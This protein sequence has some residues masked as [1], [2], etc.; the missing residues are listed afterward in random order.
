MMIDRYVREEIRRG[1]CSKLSRDQYKFVDTGHMY[2][3]ILIK[4]DMVASINML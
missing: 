1:G 4:F 2:Q 3:K